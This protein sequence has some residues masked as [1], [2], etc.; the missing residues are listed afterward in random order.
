[1]EKP[2]ITPGPWEK[3]SGVGNYDVA[4]TGLYESKT[5]NCIC[6]F[7]HVHSQNR[8]EAFCANAR[9]IA[10]VPELLAALEKALSI[11]EDTPYPGN[12]AAADIRAA[13]EKAGYGF[14]TVN[15]QP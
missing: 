14:D 15:I 9:A 8:P 12:Y 6:S 2:N 11:I 1:M 5:G 3:H 4:P 10:A 7:G 13:L